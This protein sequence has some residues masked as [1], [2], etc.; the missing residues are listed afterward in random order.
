VKLQVD[1]KL[2]RIIAYY[3]EVYKGRFLSDVH[4]E[5]LRRDWYEA[6]KFFFSK[7]FFQGRQD[8]IS[9]RFFRNTVEFL[10]GLMKWQR[11]FQLLKK[12][13]W[14][15]LEKL[16]KD[17]NESRDKKR[18]F[19]KERDIDMVIDTFKFIDQ[20]DDKNIVNYSLNK[21]DGGE[22][23]ELWNSLRQNITQVGPKIA[24]FYL[25][26]LVSLFGL[27]SKISTDEQIIYLFPIDTW[28]RKI[29]IKVGIASS[30]MKDREI[31]DRMIN[32]YRTKSIDV[33]PLKFNMGAWY[34]GKH[35]LE[36]LLPRIQFMSI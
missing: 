8:E 4:G 11:D 20:L 30:D 26:D 21:I 35:A 13:G 16:L 18:K 27:E 19:G 10:D 15:R 14:E 29:C 25:R 17:E 23:D 9:S 3:G 1:S 31:R 22:L 32:L 36:I 2:V 7:A 28:V 24:S 34:L 5:A 6:L 12:Y 33:S